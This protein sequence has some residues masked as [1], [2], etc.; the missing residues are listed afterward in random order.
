MAPH[1]R[2]THTPCTRTRAF[3]HT[4]VVVGALATTT[5]LG[6]LFLADQYLEYTTA[7]F[8]ITDGPYGS[9]FFVT[10]GFHGFHVLLGSIWLA[11]AMANYKV[12]ALHA[13]WLE[14]GWPG[15]GQGRTRCLLHLLSLR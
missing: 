14:Q 6:V 10:T 11:T 7:P 3:A 12:G 9:T 8:T 1:C 13:P 4:Q 2:Q 5:G 15:P